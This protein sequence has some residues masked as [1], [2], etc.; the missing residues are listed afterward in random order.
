MICTA[1]RKGE[2]GARRA[3]A[4]S[5]IELLI[6][7]TIL[8]AIVYVLFSIFNETQRAMRNSQVQTD[9][10]ERARAVM[11]MIAREIEQA[12][13]TFVG[14]QGILETNMFGGPEH[15]PQIISTG[16][17]D[18]RPDV[19]PRT[20]FLHNLFF[21]QKRTNAWMAVGYRVVNVTNSVGVLERY[22]TPQ[23]EIVRGSRPYFNTLSS[24]FVN[25]PLESTNYHHVADG[26]I[27]FSVIPYDRYGRRLGWDTTNRM[28][29]V[30]SIWRQNADGDSLPLVSDTELTNV[31]TVVLR[32]FPD[33]EAEVLEYGSNFA[34]K[35]N[36]MP[37]SVDVQLGILEP[38]A[39]TQYY[40]M[41]EEENPNAANFLQRQIASVHLFRQRIPI[42]TAVQ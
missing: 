11:E 1:H 36:A 41:L 4:F 13:P 8:G 14:L 34:F 37:A 40:R 3:W 31:A 24:N 30:Y 27:H 20:N 28:P 39:L 42:R 16:R 19:S 15:A 2:A 7:V 33:I 6:A 10:S 25:Q 38:E 9:V 26:V 32:A 22:E 5:V 23:E 18:A 35:S 12:Q 29:E 17:A 21:L